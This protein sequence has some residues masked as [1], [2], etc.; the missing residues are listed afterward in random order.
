MHVCLWVLSGPFVSTCLSLIII[1]TFH[2]FF[3][4]ITSP[5]L[6]GYNQSHVPF[7][8]PLCSTLVLPRCS[9]PEPIF[10]AFTPADTAAPVIAQRFQ[11]R[12]TV[13][14]VWSWVNNTYSKFS[15]IF[16]CV[17]VCVTLDTQQYWIFWW[18]MA[19]SSCISPLCRV[20]RPRFYRGNQRLNT[21]RPRPHSCQKHPAT[22]S[23]C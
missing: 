13:I 14:A 4:N 17:R 2:F 6:L 11:T 9:V 18:K 16:K 12:H 7:F 23:R 22:W 20:G 10:K 3:H 8:P 21:P 5:V 1:W 19:P 15:S